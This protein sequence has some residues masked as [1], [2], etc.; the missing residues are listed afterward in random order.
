MGAW[1]T[2]SKVGVGRA[3]R[4]PRRVGLALGVALL[5]LV[6]PGGCSVVPPAATSPEIMYSSSR[7][8]SG[9]SLD[10][11]TVDGT[12][13]VYVDAQSSYAAVAFYVDDPEMAGQATAVGSSAPFQMVLDTGTLPNGTNS[14]TVDVTIG[15][16][17]SETEVVS[18]ARFTVT[19]KATGT[20][21]APTVDA[22]LDQTVTL[23]TAVALDGRVGDDGLPSGRLSVAWSKVSGPGSVSFDD[24]AAA[25]TTATFSAAGIYTVRLGAGDGA[26]NSS[27]DAHITVTPLPPSVSVPRPDHVVVVI[28]ENHVYTDIY[29]SRSA[30]YMTSLA[31][32]GALFTES[33]AVGHPSEPNYLDLFSGSNQGV[34]DDSCSH[35]FTTANLAGALIDAGFSFGAYSEDLPSV[36]STVC[37]NKK[38]A[39]KHDPW[40]NWPSIP[41][42]AQMPFT[43]FPTDYST[44]PDVLFVIPNL[45]NDM[46]DGSIARGDAWLQNNIDAYAQWATT[47]NSLLIVTYDEGSDSND[48]IFT[49][50]YGQ[51][52]TRGSYSEHIDHFD[53]LRTLEEMYG[54]SPMG[55]SSSATPITDVWTNR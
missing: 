28:E 34:T 6:S 26:L 25:S 3:R 46:H 24:V 32:G 54:L 8:P 2:L 19:N 12:I 23:G 21:A 30:P 45:D 43:S 48:R 13:T 4:V 49:V 14:L 51:N 31:D 47:H 16:G 29:G 20:N 15:N 55:A 18:N 17:R 40:V 9:L 1:D 38:Y 41:G 37:R 35:T 52:V 5:V 7:A 39:R 53:V 50:F 10:G 44:L 36:G 22:G 42:S 27:D 11:S 33:Y